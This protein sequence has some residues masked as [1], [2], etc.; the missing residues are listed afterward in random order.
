MKLKHGGSD[1]ENMDK[2]YWRKESNLDTTYMNEYE[3]II[4]K[5]SKEEL[6]NLNQLKKEKKKKYK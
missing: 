1:W 4:N 6:I 5:E 3:E 2:E